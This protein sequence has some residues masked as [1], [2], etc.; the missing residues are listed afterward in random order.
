MYYIK[1]HFDVRFSSMKYFH[2]DSINEDFFITTETEKK[3]LF[4]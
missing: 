2:F 1:V 3:L 4:L